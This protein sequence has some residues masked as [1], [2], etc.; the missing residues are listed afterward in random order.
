MREQKSTGEENG[1]TARG[2]LFTEEGIK[3]KRRP[4][5]N[6]PLSKRESGNNCPF[7]PNKK[8]KWR[9]DRENQ[10]NMSNKK[11]EKRPQKR[12]FH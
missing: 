7:R 5:S 3:K 9:V 4:P 6:R 11:T 12:G 2:P 8:K 10:G 1:G